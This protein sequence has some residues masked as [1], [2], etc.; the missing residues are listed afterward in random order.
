MCCTADWCVGSIIFDFFVGVELNPRF[1]EYWDFKFFHNGRPGIVAWSLIDLSFM[2]LQYQNF[3]YVSNSMLI[4]TL[5]HTM[6][7]VDFF[8]NEDWYLRTIDICHDHFGYMLAWGDTTFLPTI[9]TLQ[10]QYL[11]RYPVNL[12]TT[13]A[14]AVLILG[15]SG[16]AMFRQAN[17]Q[18]DVIRF[19]NGK[20]KIWGEPAKYV[21]CTYKTEDGKTHESLLL[22]SG[23]WG[24]SRHANYL[25]DLIQSWA[26]CATCGFTHILPW[27]YFFV[28]FAILWTRT[29]RVE[30]RC[31]RKY[32]KQWLEYCNLVQYKLIPGVV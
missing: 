19:T 14:L 7:A 5:L 9:Y 25:A 32:G 13:Q 24:F 29:G 30:E 3:G 10:V 11:G 4:V 8:Y 23:W 31:H 6:Y 22:S 16:Y 2:A 28:M 21:R 18:K 20:A 1:G 17:H 15:L 12:T 27:T 26:M